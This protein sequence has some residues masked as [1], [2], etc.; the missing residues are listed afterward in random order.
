MRDT[1][2]IYV[3]GCAGMIGSNLT[4]ALLAD[5]HRVVGIDN[6]WRGTRYNIEA[7]LGI[8]NFEFRHA[9]IAADTDWA[10]DINS[11]SMI[12]H[13]ADI[14][15]G[16][17]YVFA[18]EW[19]ILRKNN[20]INTQVARVVNTQEPARI[21][22]LG[23]ACSYPQQLQMSVEESA[24][25]ETLKFPAHPESGYGWSKLLGEIEF[26]L[27]VKGRSTKLITLD[28]HNVYGWPCVYRD[29]TSQVIP[30]L[31]FKA[32]TSPDRTLSV[33][34]DGRQGRA[35]LHVDDVV[36]AVRAALAYGGEA[37]NFMIGP[38]QCTTIREV[39]E[40]VAAHPETGIAH[41]VYD[42][43]KPT[44]DIGR[45]ADGIKAEAE[46]GWTPKVELRSGLFDLIDRIAADFRAKVSGENASAI[47]AWRASQS[48]W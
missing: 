44:G 8:S 36:A 6:F 19:A 22:Y 33:W 28:L 16:I 29:E 20:L 31:I 2:T 26:K 46:L 41:I 39:A 27:A 1:V 11:S 47:C 12:V 3:T 30:S 13:T 48:S 25:N 21:I 5:G 9:D 23:T 34:G 42:T 45:F 35:F 37:D 14:V 32:L 43:T 15:A 38:R 7:F 10:L 4:R 18:K 24:L 40:L 17:G